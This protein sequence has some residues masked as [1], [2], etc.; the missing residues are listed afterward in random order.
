[1]QGSLPFY[2]ELSYRATGEDVSQLRAALV[3]L[4]YLKDKGRVFD[5]ATR[6]AVKA[7]QKDLGIPQTG[8]VRLG[9]LVAV[10]KLKVALLLDETVI[11]KGGVLAGGEKIV[12]GASGEPTFT[13]VLSEQQARLV[14]G[15]A[16]VAI[17]FDGK[18]WD[19]VI[20]VTETGENNDV[21]MQLAAPGGGAVCGADCDL[22]STGS[23]LS[24]LSRVA[25][26]PP[27]TGPAVPVASITT[28]ADGATSVVVVDETGAR[29]PRP[30]T[31]LGSQDGVAVVDGVEPGDRV[32]VLAAAP[33]DGDGTPEPTPETPK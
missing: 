28:D 19:A 10:P 18:H 9:E 25:I 4:G 5:L 20:A 27:A 30:V 16:T 22:V 6:T 2:R 3:K 24:I 32:Q 8:T 29:A 12:Y 26:V 23:K 14:P 11:A 17:E 15:S 33:K 7:W 13:L 31:I 21:R 1:M